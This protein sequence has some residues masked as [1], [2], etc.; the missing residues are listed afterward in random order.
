[1]SYQQRFTPGVLLRK[2]MVYVC[3]VYGVLYG[4]TL[5]SVYFLKGEKS[6]TPQLQ[7]Y[8]IS[9]SFIFHQEEHT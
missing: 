5:M 1:M 8:Q 9:F 6:S 3:M 7:I 4:V 2:L